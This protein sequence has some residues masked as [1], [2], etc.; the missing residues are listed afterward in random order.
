MQIARELCLPIYVATVD[1]SKAFTSVRHSVV[2]KALKFMLGR[3]FCNSTDAVHKGVMIAAMVARLLKQ[4]RA[5]VGLCG[6]ESRFFKLMRGIPQ[7]APLS[8]IL[9]AIV[10]DYILY[11]LVVE[12]EKKNKNWFCDSFKLSHVLFADDVVLVAMSRSA[13]QEVIKDLEEALTKA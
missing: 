6:F 8:A 12:W 13:L 4:S 9:W 11:T 1:I 3:A 7:G 10:M 2:I 5:K